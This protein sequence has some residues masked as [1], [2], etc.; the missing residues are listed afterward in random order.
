M[1]GR[2]VAFIA[3]VFR[4]NMH[5]ASSH[6]V[7]REHQLALELSADEKPTRTVSPVSKRARI[8]KQE[9]EPVRAVPDIE[10][11][12]PDHSTSHRV[13]Q[14]LRQ[15]HGNRKPDE[16]KKTTILDSLVETM[17]SQATTGAN[18]R[19]AFA[20]LKE[21]FPTWA[22]AHAAS[23]QAIADSIRV[24]GLA[25]AKSVRIKAILDSIQ[26][27]RGELSLEHLRTESNEQI[28]SALA[29]YP[30]VGPK[31]IACVLMFCLDRGEFPVDTHVR[32]IC[33]RLGWAARKANAKSV[34]ATMNAALPDDIKYELHV[35]LIEHGRKICRSRAP[36]CRSCMLSAECKYFA[37]EYQSQV[38]KDEP[39]IVPDG[40]T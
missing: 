16:S 13:L 39:S 29:P 19:R 8:D 20:S 1:S 18:S 11:L 7:K 24:G 3:P 23:A 37:N 34:Y 38:K 31:T 6:P 32:R 15:M 40:T 2:I 21:S 12:A 14:L 27:E 9:H 22:D 36:Q 30:G 26:K 17:L 10:D 35:L 5:R 25:D 4:L 28:K 33:E